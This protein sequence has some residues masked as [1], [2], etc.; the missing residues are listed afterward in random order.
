VTTV[1]TMAPAGTR[2][3]ERSLASS[4]GRLGLGLLGA[5][6]R[7]KATA[8]VHPSDDVEYPQDRKM[9]SACLTAETG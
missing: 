9:I 3:P 8:C 4:D 1:I 2:S 5:C 7:A 6:L